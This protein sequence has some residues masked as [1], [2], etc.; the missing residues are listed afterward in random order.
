LNP[1]KQV[2][3]LG[4]HSQPP[5]SNEEDLRNRSFALSR[6]NMNPEIACSRDQMPLKSSKLSKHNYSLQSLEQKI[7]AQKE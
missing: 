3:T 2:Q 7:W 4:T 5:L 1:N 6:I